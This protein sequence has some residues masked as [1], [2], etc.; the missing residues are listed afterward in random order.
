MNRNGM[1]VGWSSRAGSNSTVGATKNRRRVVPAILALEDRRL[2]AT[3]TVTSTA[4][5]APASNPAAG[6]LRWAV[7]QANLAT[8]PSTIN[9]NLGAGHRRSRSTRVSSI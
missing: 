2:L 8:S 1:R 3:F 7:E 4:D 6:T 5:T 9:F